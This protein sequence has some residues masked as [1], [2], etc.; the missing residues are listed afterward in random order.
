MI[1]QDKSL[2]YELLRLEMIQASFLGEAIG[3]A[4]QKL[5]YH[6]SNKVH[7]IFLELNSKLFPLSI[8]YSTENGAWEAEMP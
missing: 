5:K 2:F 7:W 6:Q 8:K 4:H 1:F 3:L